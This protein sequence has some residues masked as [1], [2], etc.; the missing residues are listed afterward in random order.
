MK[1]VPR[2]NTDKPLAEYLEINFGSDSGITC[3]S[4]A[5]LLLQQCEEDLNFLRSDLSADGSVGKSLVSAIESISRRVFHARLFAQSRV[6]VIYF[7][8]ESEVK[9]ADK[10]RQLLMARIT[11]L[12]K[13]VSWI[14][15]LEASSAEIR[16]LH[17]MHEFLLL[18]ARYQSLDGPNIEVRE[19]SP[20]FMIFV[21]RE[22]TSDS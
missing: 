9:A 22:S 13:R 18:R 1:L 7:P 12:N 19:S 15:K 20:L 4:S 14:S 21:Q 5:P 2:S 3:L 17:N 16:R 11:E 10:E 6:L 8:Q